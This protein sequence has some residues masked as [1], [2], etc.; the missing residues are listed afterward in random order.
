MKTVIHEQRGHPPEVLRVSEGAA[1]PPGPGEVRVEVLSTPIHNADLL[2]VQ[3]LYGRSPELPATPGSEA[4]GRVLELG[5]GVSQLAVGATVFLTTGA[6]WTQQVTAPASAFVPLPP[7]DLDQ[8]AMLVSSPATAHLMLER[9]GDLQPGDWLV[10]SAANSAVG[11]AVVQ[12]ARARGLRTVN[13][14]RREEVV[15]E[16]VTLG[17]DVVLVGTDDLVARVQRATGGASIRLAFDA[18]GGEV[19]TRLLDVLAMGG[20]LVSYSQV[21]LGAAAVTPGDLIFKQLTVSGFWLSQW[22]AEAS[23]D[24]KQALFGQLVPLV[25]GGR[26]RMAVDSTWTLDQVGDAVRRSMG[27][28]RNGKVLFH[29]NG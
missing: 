4:V 27:G 11:S 23:A 29:P 8:L 24:D 13:I 16:L 20:T 5:E 10:Q 28:R 15:D 3:G 22:F 26:L 25:A 21:E 14:V 9:Y 1:R 2:Q 7:G 19:F 12:L 18:I 6:T 17:A